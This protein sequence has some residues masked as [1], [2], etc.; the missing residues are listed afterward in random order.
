MFIQS[1][2]LSKYLN[3][4]TKTLWGGH[5]GPYYLHFTTEGKEACNTYLGYQSPVGRAWAK[6]LPS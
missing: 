4:F 6:I 2:K 1:F 5:Y 3:I